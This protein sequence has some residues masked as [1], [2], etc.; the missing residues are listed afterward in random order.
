MIVLYVDDD[1]DDV[2]IFTEAVAE[3]APDTLL[4]VASTAEKAIEVLNE[5]IVLPDFIFLDIN[6]TLTSGKEF[7]KEL[8]QTEHLKLISVVMYSTT[9]DIQEI[10][11]CKKL[12]ATDFIVKPPEFKKLC[13]ALREFL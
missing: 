11:D 2:D 4:H 5:L 1:K 10:E 7:L 13:E 6:L 9:N 12:G 8:K 3:I